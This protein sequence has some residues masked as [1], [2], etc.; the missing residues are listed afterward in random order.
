MMTK[1]LKY[2]TRIEYIFDLMKDKNKSH[3][4]R[5]TFN[6]FSEDFEK[7]KQESGAYNIDG[8]WLN[9]KRYFLTF[10]EWYNSRELYHLVGF[11]IATGSEVKSLKKASDKHSKSAFKN[12]LK[13]KISK[14]VNFDI[15]ELKYGKNSNEIRRVLLLFN[16]ET[17]LRNNNSHLRFPFDRYKSEKWDIEHVRSQTDYSITGKKRYAYLEEILS[18]FTGE[19]EREKQEAYLKEQEKEQDDAYKICRKSIAILTDKKM[20]D[21]DFDNLYKE[22]TAYFGEETEPVDIDNI[23]NL[24]LLDFGTNRGYGNSPFPVKRKII[25]E[26]DTSGI[27]IPLC[28]KNVFM[29]SYSK[30]IGE[31]MRWSKTDADNYAEAIQEILT[32]YLP[33]QK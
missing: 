8:L 14:K 1:T 18:Y 33:T 15:Q 9:I 4:D 11:L 22:I 25:L 3:E 30:K 16:I 21:A 24:A 13:E 12:Y 26:N 2:D 28:T 19:K 23:S 27:F 10:Q 29:K 31:I 5:H 6:K 20:T 7:S 17:L 32:P